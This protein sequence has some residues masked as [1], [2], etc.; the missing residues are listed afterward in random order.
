MG[1]AGLSHPQTSVRGW[2]ERMWA[3]CLSLRDFASSR[4]THPARDTTQ[5]KSAVRRVF[6]PP[7]DSV[8]AGKRELH[9]FVPIR[10]HSWF[11]ITPLCIFLRV[12]ASSRESH[13]AR[14]T[15]HRKSAVRRVFEPPV[16][17]ARAGKREL[18][19]DGGVD[20]AGLLIGS[21]YYG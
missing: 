18:R 13:P 1:G 20:E 3:L 16:D 7:G 6:E 5:R 21:G 12:F 19:G 4:E 8:R 9:L 17:S 2:P 11:Q 15:T 14:V 10:V